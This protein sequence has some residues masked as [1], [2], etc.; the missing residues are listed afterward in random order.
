MLYRL[1]YGVFTYA[2]I[3]RGH[4]IYVCVARALYLGILALS[5][6]VRRLNL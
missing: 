3:E 1:S 5:L 4:C 2:Y 6:T